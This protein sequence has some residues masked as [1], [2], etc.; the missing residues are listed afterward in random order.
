M[1]HARHIRRRTAALALVALGAALALLPGTAAAKEAPE[2]AWFGWGTKFAVV[3][4][5]PTVTF[6]AYVAVDGTPVQFLAEQRTEIACSET[7]D[8]DVVNGKAVFDGSSYLTCQLPSWEEA[9]SAIGYD[10]PDTGECMVCATGGAPIWGDMEVTP[11]A[12]VSGVMPIVDA[13]DAGIRLSVETTGATARAR[14]DVD[15]VLG[16]TNI[17]TYRS[18]SWNIA[19]APLAHAVVGMNGRGIVAVANHFQWLDYLTGDWEDFFR[20]SVTGTRVG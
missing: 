19:T 13:S 14:L 1:T 7:G 18:T 16:T 20:N 2:G 9:T 5:D 8:I 17:N 12:G 11:A 6:I 4:G 3:N 15:R 10:L